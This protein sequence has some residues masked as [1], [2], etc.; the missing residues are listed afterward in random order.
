MFHSKCSFCAVVGKPV[1][2]MYLLII[3]FLC[4]ACPQAPSHLGVAACFVLSLAFS[5]L[6]WLY[7]ML[8]WCQRSLFIEFWKHLKMHARDTA[9]ST[10]TQNSQTQKEP[11]Q[12]SC[13]SSLIEPVN[14]VT[15]PKSLAW[16]EVD[17][18][19]E[20]RLI[21]GVLFLWSLFI[22]MRNPTLQCGGTLEMCDKW[23][24]A[25]CK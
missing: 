23:G 11:F 18:L 12:F 5:L 13:F 15:L 8:G 1:R 22:Q 16:P 10:Q 4:L 24:K 17:L 9:D 2:L 14:P 19:V 20:K 21:A 25:P 7:Y 3:I 6:P